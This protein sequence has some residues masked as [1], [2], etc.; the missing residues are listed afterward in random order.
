M[1]SQRTLQEVR[2]SEPILAKIL[3][4]HGL[5]GILE[6]ETWRSIDVHLPLIAAAEAKRQSDTR[7][8]DRVNP[9]ADGLRIVAAQEAEMRELQAFVT[10]QVASL[11]HAVAG[12]EQK[13]GAL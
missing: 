7:Y 6:K 1:I 3:Q 11:R 10:S 8:R 2:G 12:V 13:L 4:E 9:L 5:G